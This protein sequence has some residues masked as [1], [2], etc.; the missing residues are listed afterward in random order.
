VAG[1][2]HPRRIDSVREPARAPVEQTIEQEGDIGRTLDDELLHHG[3]RLRNR[4]SGLHLHQGLHRVDGRI[5]DVVRRGHDVAVARQV[6]AKEGALATVSAEAMG[7][8]NQGKTPHG[9][10]GVAYS[11]LGNGGESGKDAVAIARRIREVV[12]C[13]KS[14]RRVPDL[15]GK[16]AL[17]G[18][19]IELAGAHAD[20]V[21]AA[22]K[23]VV[24]HGASS[25]TQRGHAG[26]AICGSR[27]RQGVA[28]RVREG[29]SRGSNPLVC[30]QGAAVLFT[31]GHSRRAAEKRF[32]MAGLK[33]ADLAFREKGGVRFALHPAGEDHKASSLSDGVGSNMQALARG[34]A[35]RVEHNAG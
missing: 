24:G 26:P 7:E 13:V 28:D 17:A 5:A 18:A 15:E 23:G 4:L 34:E 31:A 8:R 25:P 33:H 30:A 6:C 1:H 12:A 14:L 3:L 11:I 9:R 29:E 20:S 21:G 10:L 27:R 35:V 32:G 19:V 2:A 16:C 22:G